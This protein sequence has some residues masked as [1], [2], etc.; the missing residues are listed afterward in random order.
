MHLLPQTANRRAMA[1]A[2]VLHLLLLFALL[3]WGSPP[4]ALSTPEV[5]SNL[6]IVRLPKPPVKKIP[7][8]ATSGIKL[9]A[10]PSV[11]LPSAKTLERQLATLPKFDVEPQLT[12]VAVTDPLPNLAAIDVAA[13]TVG[14][15]G[16]GRAGAGAGSTGSGS[17]PSGT[18]PA[19]G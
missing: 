13:T 1:I 6:V 8:P 12:Q 5:R 14:T 18:G 11:G 10:R 4:S 19:V 16:T 17:G 2:L 7:E 3:R 15:G 9:A